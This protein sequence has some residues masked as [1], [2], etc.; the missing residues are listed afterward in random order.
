MLTRIE[1][2]AGRQKSQGHASHR[3]E[4]QVR[5]CSLLSAGILRSSSLH[6]KL[7]LMPSIFQ[8]P[9]RGERSCLEMPSERSVQPFCPKVI[10]EHLPSTHRGQARRNE[11]IVDMVWKI[12]LRTEL[13]RHDLKRPDNRLHIPSIEIRQ[14]SS[15]T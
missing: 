14:G 7:L 2:D 11:D 8:N 12:L 5:Q 6:S 9:V 13:L 4:D 3:S 10:L 15:W 1:A